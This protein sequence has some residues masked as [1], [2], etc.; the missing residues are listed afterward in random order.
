LG[1]TLIG[2]WRI[3]PKQ[4]REDQ[5]LEFLNHGPSTWKQLRQ[6]LDVEEALLKRTVSWLKKR[7]D[8][9]ERNGVLELADAIGQGNSLIGDCSNSSIMAPAR[10]RRWLPRAGGGPTPRQL[11]AVPIWQPLTVIRR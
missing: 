9:R 3:E 11:S 1:T 8:I 4:E 2:A 10:R 6:A 7:A 5:V